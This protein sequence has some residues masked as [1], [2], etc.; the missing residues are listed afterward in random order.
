MHACDYIFMP[1]FE[2]PLSTIAFYMLVCHRDIVLLTYNK[3][4]LS[5]VLFLL[6]FTIKAKIL[7]TDSEHSANKVSFPLD[8]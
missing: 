5:N 1:P 6:R 7:S 2:N 4:F 8:F 3:D